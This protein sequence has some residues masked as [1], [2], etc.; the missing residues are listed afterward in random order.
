MEIVTALLCILGLIIWFANM[1]NRPQRIDVT[2]PGKEL[3]AR[4]FALGTGILW[5]R[6]WTRSS[7]VSDLQRPE[8]QWRTANGCFNGRQLAIILCCFSMPKG[9]L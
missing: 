4:F 2:A 7:R 5:G 9:A 1:F 6:R 8:A 3:R